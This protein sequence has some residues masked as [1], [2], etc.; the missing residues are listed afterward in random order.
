MRI[1]VVA[2]DTPVDAFFAFRSAQALLAFAPD[3]EVEIAVQGEPGSVW[4]GFRTALPGVAVVGGPAATGAVPAGA[5]LRPGAAV[6]YPETA[7]TAWLSDPGTPPGDVG[8]YLD[9]RGRINAVGLLD[10]RH[11]DEALRPEA[12]VMN[13][14]F[15]SEFEN[16]LFWSYRY[17]V[18]PELG[19]GKGSRGIYVTVKRR[20]LKLAGIEDAESILDVGCGD[21]EVVHAL[22][23]NGY[24]GLDLAETALD[25][26]RA[27]RPE[28]SFEVGMVDPERHGPRDIVLCL[29]VLIHQRDPNAFAALIDGLVAATGQRLIVSGYEAS[30]GPGYMIGFHGPLS[31]ALAATGAFERIVTVARYRGTSLIIADRA[32]SEF[33]KAQPLDTLEIG[34]IM[35]DHLDG[36]GL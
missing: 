32:G 6:D 35:F 10:L 11:V 19:S 13:R 30:A 4:E 17:A 14:A 5:L 25:R 1:Q 12:R 24:L 36:L 16:R 15:R 31:E 18:N 29:D 23:L 7:L 8:G 21:L 2:F 26:A 27:L 33:P 28:W 22:S 20:C 34:E 3:A 9:I